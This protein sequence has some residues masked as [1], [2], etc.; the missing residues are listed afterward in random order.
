M[1][2]K[3]YVKKLLV[4]LLMQ[5]PSLIPK[6]QIRVMFLQSISYFWMNNQNKNFVVVI[7]HEV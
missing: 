7:L 4:S 1:M 6:I 3:Q 2:L 5:Y